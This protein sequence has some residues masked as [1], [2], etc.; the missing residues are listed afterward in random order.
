MLG[1]YGRLMPGKCHV[2]P[3]T[4][5]DT[6]IATRRREAADSGAAP[7]FRFPKN[8]TRAKGTKTNSGKRPLLVEMIV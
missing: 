5:D 2:P 7:R 8:K 3:A 6:K 1:I 4:D